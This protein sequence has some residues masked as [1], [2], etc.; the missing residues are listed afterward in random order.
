MVKNRNLLIIAGIIWSL[1]GINILKIGILAYKDKFS[2]VH[3]IISILVF[4]TFSK[5]IFNKIVNK[6]FNRIKNYCEEKHYFWMFFDKKTL[7]TM[8]FMMTI[9][10]SL[11]KFNIL[12]EVFI[13]VFY[14]GLGLALLI[15]GLRFFKKYLEYIRII[16]KEKIKLI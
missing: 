12:S 5:F 9:G 10:I 16:D 7:F 1:A 15:S 6:N 4:L 13:A 14:T 3:S 11:K 8:I 2:L